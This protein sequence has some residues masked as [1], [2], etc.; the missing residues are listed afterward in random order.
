M[1][2]IDEAAAICDAERTEV[3]LE[4]SDLPYIARTSLCSLPGIPTILV[5][6]AERE[7]CDARLRT[8]S[9]LNIGLAWAAGEWNPSRS[10]P[11]AE[12][13]ALFEI[14]GVDWFSLQRPHDDV[15]RHLTA[16]ETPG[17]DILATALNILNLDLVISVD[18]MVAHLAGA[19]G[20]PVWLLLQ[21]HADWRW[22]LGRED[23]PWYP[24]M[25]IFRQQPCETGW[26]EV[27]GRVAA[28]IRVNPAG[29]FP[30]TRT[31]VL[32]RRSS[33]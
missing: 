17:S 8:S 24:T 1:P 4:C 15:L 16:L 9:G 23:S 14:P 6:D 7:R 28:E 22:M 27:I 26:R 13:N 25:R 33:G 30:A 2:G 19:L 20:K 10:I 29:A 11:T 3:D 12:L 5:P 18:T 32:R 31:Q 21:H